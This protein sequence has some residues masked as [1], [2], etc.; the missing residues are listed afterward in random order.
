LITIIFR[1]FEILK[2]KEAKQSFNTLL[3]HIDKAS[4][5]RVANPAYFFIRRLLTA[6]LLTM[7]IKGGFVFLQYLFILVVSHLYILY[8]V[9]KK[10]YQ[11]IGINAYVVVNEVFYSAIMVSIF[12]FS[13]A[14]PEFNIKYG[15]GICLMTSLVLLV[16]ANLITNLVCMIL[17]HDKLKKQI[18]DSKLK[19]AEREA[20]EKAEREA[21]RLK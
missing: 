13:D 6:I 14:V 8:L 10:P 16:L 20:L 12:I 15:A 4:K 11:T 2:I 7:P 5:V 17:G 9:A 19:R 3:L 18:K 21:R 1:R